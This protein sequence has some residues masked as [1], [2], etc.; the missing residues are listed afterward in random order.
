MAQEP[1]GDVIRITISPEVR[2]YMIAANEAGKQYAADDVDDVRTIAGELLP[3]GAVTLMRKATARPDR[4]IVLAIYENKFVTWF[5]NL[6]VEK[7]HC[8]GGDY[9]MPDDL[10]GALASFQERT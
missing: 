7:G 4:D 6:G 5:H 2:A 10:Q 8:T 1:E 3:N 9:F